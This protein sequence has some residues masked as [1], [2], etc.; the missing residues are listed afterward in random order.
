MKNIILVSFYF[1]KFTHP[2]FT[3]TISIH[4]KYI[5]TIQKKY[6]TSSNQDLHKI[7][8][9]NDNYKQILCGSLAVTPCVQSEN[10]IG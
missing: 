3:S 4:S 1:A 9:H 7:S 6:T 2:H 5:S 10:Q 8:H